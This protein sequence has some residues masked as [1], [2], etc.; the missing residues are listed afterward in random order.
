MTDNRSPCVT[1]REAV[2]GIAASVLSLA[3]GRPPRARREQR[4]VI[5]MCDGL[6][7]DYIAASAMPTLERW[8]RDGIYAPVR[9]LMPSVTNANNTAICCGAPPSVTGI[10]GN[11]YYDP[12]TGREAYMDRADLVLAPTLFEHAARRGVRSALL[13]S[14]KKTI[15]LLHRGAELAVTAE[16]APA[17]FVARYG[18]PPPIY[19]AEI[20]HWLLT[21]AVDLLRRRPELGC[22]YVHTTDYPMHMH[23]PAAPESRAHLA[24]LDALLGEAAAAAPDA[25]FYVTA[26]HGMNFKTSCWDLARACAA[27]DAPVRAVVSAARD[28][29]PKHHLGFGGTAWIYLN[30]PGDADRVA[31]V[32][33]GLTGVEAVLS[34]R[35]AA[36]RFVL[37]PSRIGDLMAI[38]DR[39]T[40]LGEAETEHQSLDRAYRSHGSLYELDVPLVAYNGDSRAQTASDYRMNF[41]L[42]RR[43]YR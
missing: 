7:L 9:A 29:Y 28:Q 18:A 15:G 39:D 34:R 10:T 26:D 38:G 16:E 36:Q 32:V 11:S 42:T 20:N 1:R 27:R 2:T 4:V 13:S 5:L 43:L 35:E 17:D 19:S 37:M 8:K 40:V 30:A 24:T 12:E 22:L 6:G 25:A 14:K 3:V 21:V 31:S 33:A 41:D 23:P